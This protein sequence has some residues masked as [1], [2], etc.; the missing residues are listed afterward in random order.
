MTQDAEPHL[1]RR[2]EAALQVPWSGMNSST[3]ACRENFLPSAIGSHGSLSPAAGQPCSGSCFSP[4]LHTVCVH[5]MHTKHRP[6]VHGICDMH[7]IMQ[8]R[9]HGNIAGAVAAGIHVLAAGN[10][11]WQ[12]GHG[13]TP[14]NADRACAGL[15]Q[16][17][18][19]G[20]VRVADEVQKHTCSPRLHPTRAC[21]LTMH[22]LRCLSLYQSGI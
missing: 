10:A 19:K 12:A 7:T 6:I 4:M 11:G 14:E 9:E 5:A 2:S 1:G 22:A 8:V 16:L 15:Q 20:A 18:W 13:H 3:Q 21:S 17:V